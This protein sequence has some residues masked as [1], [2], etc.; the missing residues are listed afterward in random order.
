MKKWM[1]G[2]TGLSGRKKVIDEQKPVSQGVAF[3]ITAGFH[4]GWLDNRVSWRVLFVEGMC[5]VST[6]TKKSLVPRHVQQP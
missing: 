4:Y 6:K 2:F 3:V 1:T 5:V